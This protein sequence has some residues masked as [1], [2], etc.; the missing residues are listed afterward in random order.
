M[1]TEPKPKKAIFSEEEMQ[2]FDLQRTDKDAWEREGHK[3]VELLLMC[4]GNGVDPKSFGNI[5]RRCEIWL[6]ISKEQNQ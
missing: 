2:S 6:Y 5:R 4:T 1:S 3:L